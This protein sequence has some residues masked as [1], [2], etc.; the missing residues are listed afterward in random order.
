M[1]PF[2][3]IAAGIALI[4]AYVTQPEY[5]ARV[6]TPTESK[7]AADDLKCNARE[8]SAFAAGY[9]KRP[10]EKLAKYQHEWTGGSKF[11]SV[12]W[13]DQDSNVIRYIGDRIKFQNGFGA[14][15]PHTYTCDFN[16]KTDTV[17]S[18]NASPG[19]L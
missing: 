17:V 11:T 10:I 12:K 19:R 9:C 3:F 2:F 6:S 8:N 13:A 4:L 15:Q 14:W 7:C 5:A 1:R 16:I 18:V